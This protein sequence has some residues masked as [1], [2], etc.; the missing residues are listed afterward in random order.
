MSDSSI[1]TGAAYLVTRSVESQSH[2]N[3]S[4]QAGDGDSHNP[5]EE[6]EAHTLPVDSLEGAVAQAD[7]DGRAGDAHRGGH[8]QL[9]LGEYEDG[10]CGSHLHGGT[11]G[12]GVVGDLVA[13]DCCET[14][15]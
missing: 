3:A 14:I 9:V 15:C 11:T 1:F 6:Q 10:D 13:H 4:D 2:E 12:W 8:G 5:G 7:T